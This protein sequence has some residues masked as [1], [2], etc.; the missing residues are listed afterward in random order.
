MVDALNIY[1]KHKMNTILF[2]KVCVFIMCKQMPSSQLLL[3]FH[4]DNTGSFFMNTTIFE[5]YI[6]A[7]SK[8]TEISNFGKIED[9]I[10]TLIKFQISS[11]YN[12][13]DKNLEFIISMCREKD[14]PNSTNTILYK[15]DISGYNLDECPICRIP[16]TIKNPINLPCKHKVCCECMLGLVRNHS[17]TCPVCR[18]PYI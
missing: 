15:L 17:D 13:T 10:S 1:I 5:K 14:D 16:W 3:T 11:L 2:D 7:E 9:I 6:K 4:K 18:A 12:A 8:E